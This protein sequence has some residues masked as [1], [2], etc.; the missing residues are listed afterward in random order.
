VSYE[1]K[2]DGKHEIGVVA[3]DVDQVVPELVSLDPDTKE[4]QGL[5]YSRL[6]VLLIEAVKSQQAEI[7]QL[8]I[9]VSQ[10]TS[11]QAEN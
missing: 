10:L 11:K 4:V 7:Q 2:A 9:Q 8:R 1:R 6:T 3:E 5:D